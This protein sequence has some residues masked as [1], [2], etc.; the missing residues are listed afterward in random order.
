MQQTRRRP[1]RQA[2]RQHRRLRPGAAPRGRAHRRR[3]HRAGRGGRHA[4]RRGAQDRPQRRAGGRDGQPRAGP[5][6]VPRA[7]RRLVLATPS[8][9]TS[10]LRRCCRARK[11]RPKPSKRRPRV[12]EALAAPRDPH[13]PPLAALPDKEVEFDAAMTASDRQR[14]AHA[15][16]NALGA[17]EY[18]LV[19][20]L[21]RDISAAGARGCRRGA[22]AR[23]ATRPPCA[24]ALARRA[25]RGGAH[26]RRDAA[27]AA[28]RRGASSRCR[29]WC[30]STS[31]AR[32]SAMRGCCWPSCTRPRGARAGATCSPS[33]P[34]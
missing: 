22:C 17:A 24:H 5:A 14:P 12:R 23:R 25:A 34:G 33:A 16:F 28:A 7:V 32:W 20:R 9:P 13:K 15:D 2:G 21:A 6:G 19:E 8:S 27:A 3:A 10:C 30:W 31:R 26:R 18:R 1:H 29:S 11:A 4:G